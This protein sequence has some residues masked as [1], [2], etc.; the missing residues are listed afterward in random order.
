MSVAILAQA[1]TS[2]SQMASGVVS[3]RAAFVDISNFL[4]ARR[5]E[6]RMKFVDAARLV[7]LVLG[8]FTNSSGPLSVRG[9]AAAIRTFAKDRV[10]QT[11]CSSLD[12]DIRMLPLVVSEFCNLDLPMQTWDA[13]LQSHL[14]AA[15]SQV[16]R[17]EVELNVVDSAPAAASSSDAIIAYSSA[18]GPSQTECVTRA[19][20]PIVPSY[21]DLDRD[22]LMQ[23]LAERDAHIE[24]MNLS[25]RRLRR[26]VTTLE[27]HNS[28]L[29]DSIGQH[30]ADYAVL[31][32][33][34]NFRP[35]LKRCSK[36][37]CYSMAIRC[38]NLTVL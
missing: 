15:P 17:R 21:A 34:H 9:V 31:V 4:S 27:G 37:G 14:S 10:E 11:V 22:V 5:F 38:L 7:L 35:K 13:L 12:F 18:A 16:V 8:E 25:S 33:R 2:S 24:T 3:G 29:R 20:Y 26:K 32:A 23:I 28:V 6:S 36:Y 19:V 1:I 30:K